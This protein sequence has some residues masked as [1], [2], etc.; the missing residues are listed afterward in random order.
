MI[1]LPPIDFV[2]IAFEPRITSMRLLGPLNVLPFEK[3]MCL[4]KS[5]NAQL[6][7]LNLHLMS[8]GQSPNI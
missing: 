2:L 1:C 3:Q 7:L 8:E 4:L 5:K 6:G